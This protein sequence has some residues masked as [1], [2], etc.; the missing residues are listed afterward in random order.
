[1]RASEPWVLTLLRWFCWEKGVLLR[2]APGVVVGRLL[3]PE[4][5]G[6]ARLSFICLKVEDSLRPV[7]V[8]MELDFLAINILA[9]DWAAKSVLIRGLPDVVDF[10]GSGFLRTGVAGVFFADAGDADSL[11]FALAIFL[12]LG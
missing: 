3:I 9:A 6:L 1:M 10:F 8:L 5:C 12:P 2:L 11:F 4:R 7:S